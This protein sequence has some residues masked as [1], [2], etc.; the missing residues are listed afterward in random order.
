[1][2]STMTLLDLRGITKVYPL[3]KTSVHALRGVDLTI[4]RGEIVAVMGPSGSG[5]STLMHILGALDTPTG[6]VALLDGQPLHELSEHQLATLRGRKVG[7]VFQTFNLIPTLSAQRNVELPMI[8]LGV[9]KRKRAARARELLIKVGLADRVHHRPNELSGGERQ[10]V[11]I[12]RALANDPEIILA[13]EPT[14]NLDSE[15]GATILAL[16]K[17]LSTADGKTV[18]LVTHDPDAARIADR[19]VRMRDGRVIEEMSHGS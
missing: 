3:G 12:A 8:F 10:R 18:V 11:A 17:S 2:R 19:I 7:F 13:D 1:M 15:T 5:K 14:G 9:P 6:G 4:E 16:L